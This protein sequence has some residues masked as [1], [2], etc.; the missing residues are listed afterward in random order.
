MIPIGRQLSRSSRRRMQGLTMLEL[1]VTLAIVV[2]LAGIS[3]PAMTEFQ[4]RN[5][6][7]T[8]TNDMVVA[9]NMARAEAVKR[10][11]DVSVVAAGN[12]SAG[13]TVQTQVGNEV[14]MQRDALQPNYRVL[15]AAVGVGAP[16]DRVVF[17]PTG[18]LRIATAYNFS[19]CRPSFDPGDAQSRRIAVA[20]T[21]TIR[22]RRDTTGAPAGACT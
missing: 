2:I 16:A 21:G 1:L 9:L 17:G 18:A 12:W 14:I 4:V 5:N 19:V 8:A 22:A 7:S 10:G 13:W 20:A 15:G 3:A 11:L 6:V